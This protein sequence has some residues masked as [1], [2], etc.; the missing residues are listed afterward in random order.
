M[1]KYL[2]TVW[3]LLVIAGLLTAC[4]D[5][6]AA[7][8]D[9]SQTN[10]VAA[11]ATTEKESSDFKVTLLGTGSPIPQIDR[12][13]GSTLVE[14]GGEK[15]LFDAGRGSS[16]RLLQLGIEAGEINKMFFTHL[17]HD[18]TI[19]FPDIL[20]TGSV[21]IPGMGGRQE[22]L[23]VWGPSG[24]QNMI[25]GFYQAYEKDLTNRQ[26]V[27]K[28][29]ASGLDTDVHEFEEGVIYNHNGV[30]VFAF[31]V[32]HGSMKPSFGFRINYDGKSVVIAG[33]TTYSENLIKHAKGT[34][35]MIHEVIV[36]ESDDEVESNTFNS[37][38]SYHSTPE[39]AAEV[40]KAVNPKLAVYTHIISLGMT[41][42]E[43]NFVGRTNKI[44]DGEVLLGEDLMSFKL[45]EEITVDQP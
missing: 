38:A 7:K 24:T 30:E 10:Q 26:S 32:D 39:Q 44:Y 11:V 45:G 14:V 6:D 2:L 34:D 23:Q 27:A 28:S 15:L 22:A 18:H 37:I 40:F 31:E 19:G 1:R 33:D 21:P 36:T 16:M 25:D 9:E 35:L 3:A 29:K 12:F 8:E 4:S 43:A 41:D 13:G 17:H 5:S 20:I 42:S